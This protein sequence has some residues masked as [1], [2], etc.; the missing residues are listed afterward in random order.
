LE[1]KIGVMEVIVLQTQS[2][3]WEALYI[4]GNLI[5]EGSE[6][7]EGL[8]RLYF[9]RKAEEYD[10]SSKDIKFLE[11]SNDD[12]ELVSRSGCFPD[13]IYELHGDYS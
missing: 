3:D 11:I 10:F 6:L 1:L 8:N 12:E 13:V 7:G 5:D 2:A 4:N 9:L